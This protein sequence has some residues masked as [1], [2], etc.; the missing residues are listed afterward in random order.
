MANW[1]QAP[2]MRCTGSMIPQCVVWQCMSETGGY[3]LHW[4]LADYMGGRLKSVSVKYLMLD[5]CF[6]LLLGSL[7]QHSRTTES[8]LRLHTPSKG[9]FRL[10]LT[11]STTH[12]GIR[13]NCSL[14][15]RS[16]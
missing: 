9:T 16:A 7:S 5:G 15:Q 12:E 3:H 8:S 2:D 6:P 1:E 13:N 14:G 11:A 4:W 10:L